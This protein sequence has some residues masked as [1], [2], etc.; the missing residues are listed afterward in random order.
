MSIPWLDEAPG[1]WDTVKLGP[2]T[3]P[4][5]ARLEVTVKESLDIKKPM[6][7]A[8]ATTTLQGSEPARV[9]IHLRMW[10]P[11]HLDAWAAFIKRY[12]S[13]AKTNAASAARNALKITH[14][15]TALYG[16]A[17]VLIEEISDAVNDRGDIYDV[18]IS[19][20]EFTGEPKGGQTKTEKKLDPRAQVLSDDIPAAPEKP[21]RT[22][23]GPNT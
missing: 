10:E 11:D 20:T 21:S 8:G 5:L 17:A 15:K 14:P 22:N 4:G 19:C 12:R 13:R 7:A 16:V 18:K 9:V 3:L 6:G 23:T 2:V 1:K